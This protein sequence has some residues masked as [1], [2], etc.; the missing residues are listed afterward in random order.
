[1]Q[2]EIQQHLADLTPAIFSYT[3]LLSLIATVA[4]VVAA[5]AAVVQLRQRRSR[6]SYIEESSQQHPVFPTSERTTSSK[7]Q[8]RYPFIPSMFD[9]GY[10]KPWDVLPGSILVAILQL[11]IWVI[12]RLAH[13]KADTWLAWLLVSLPLGLFGL[14]AFI[15]FLF[16][17]MAIAYKVRYW[18]LYIVVCV[19]GAALNCAM[20]DL[21]I[22]I[23]KGHLIIPYSIPH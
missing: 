2:A 12:I 10:V 19:P 9:N 3:G 15:M 5:V 13:V 1:M 16:V 21:A 17:P 11:C 6:P 22:S 4:A 7:G 14:I 23:A 18:L 8:D 20:L